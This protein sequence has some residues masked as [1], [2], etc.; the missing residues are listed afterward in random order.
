[1][2]KG[3]IKSYNNA[4]LAI[5]QKLSDSEEGI[6]QETDFLDDGIIEIKIERLKKNYSMVNQEL[7]MLSKYDKKDSYNADK[8]EGL[9]TKKNEISFEIAFLGSNSF[10]S[11][12]TC[13]NLIKEMDTDF[14]DCI[15]ALQYYKVGQEKKAF[16]IFYGYFKNRKGILNH[17]LINKVY[18]L[19]LYKYEQYNLAIP[20]L[21][22]ATEKRPEDIESHRILK[23]IYSSLNMRQEEQIEKNILAVLGESV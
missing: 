12:D 13:A 6:V 18:G 8:I 9:R 4:K 22:T 5:I 17:Y 21:R 14:K 2:I 3:V 20:L 19:L 7:E 15:L 11:L 16:E 10:N 1:M 23:E